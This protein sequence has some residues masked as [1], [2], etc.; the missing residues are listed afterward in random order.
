MDDNVPFLSQ[1]GIDF[2]EQLPMSSFGKILR[3]EVRS[4]YRTTQTVKV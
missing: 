4:P 3:R 2:V 1:K